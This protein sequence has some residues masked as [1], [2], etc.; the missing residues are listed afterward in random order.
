LKARAK[1]LAF[2]VN[3]KQRFVLNQGTFQELSR[4]KKGLSL[5]T[6]PG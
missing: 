6:R 1:A 2:V 5:G 4:G 3:Q